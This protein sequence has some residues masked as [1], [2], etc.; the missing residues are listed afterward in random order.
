[1]A[2]NWAT[3]STLPDPNGLYPGTCNQGPGDGMFS[4]EWSHKGCIGHRWAEQ[5]LAVRRD[6]PV[7]QR[8]PGFKN[9]CSISSRGSG[10]DR[11]GMESLLAERYQAHQR[12]RHLRSKAEC[13]AR[14]DGCC[15]FILFRHS[16]LPT[17]L[18]HCTGLPK[19]G[20]IRAPHLHPG[21]GNFAMADGS[22][23]FLKESINPPTYRALATRAGGEVISADQY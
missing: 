7:P 17:G 6:V 10:L 15:T 21:G 22:V 19:P 12:S 16:L 1:M 18:D 20:A 5:Y 14:Y 13:P 9:S 8:T 2:I 11:R 23:H 3:T 4:V